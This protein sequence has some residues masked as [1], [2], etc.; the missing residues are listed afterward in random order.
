MK[1]TACFLITL[2]L[3]LCAGTVY[4]QENCKTLN[5]NYKPDDFYINP[6]DPLYDQYVPM[7][8][9]RFGIDP[10]TFEW[11]W[12]QS[13]V[14]TINGRWIACGKMD[15]AIFDPFA[16]GINPELWGNPGIMITKSGNLFTMSYGLSKYDDGG[17][18]IAFGGVSYFEGSSGKYT[19]TWGWAA[20]R[21]KHFPPTFEIRSVGYLCPPE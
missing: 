2:V 14:G 9:A 13:I 16:L 11:C 12:T 15:L 8:E 20:D 10:G 17:A 4:A 6:G 21:P 1:R 5:I 7:I 3:V 18:W 19:G